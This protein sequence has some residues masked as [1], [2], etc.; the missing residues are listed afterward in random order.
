MSTLSTIV[1]TLQFPRKVLYLILRQTEGTKLFWRSIQ[2]PFQRTEPDVWKAQ[3]AGQ[4]LIVRELQLAANI[5]SQK[6]PLLIGLHGYGSDE[7]QMKTL[8]GVELDQPFIYLAPRAP[9]PHPTGGYAWFPINVNTGAVNNGAFEFEA[10]QIKSSLDLIAALIPQAV[11]RY[12]A[13][14]ERVFV[15]GYSQGAAMSLAFML[16]H[17]QRIAG[18]A[19]MSGQLLDAI[20]PYVVPPLDQQKPFFLG[21]GTKDQFITPEGMTAAK[22]YLTSRNVAVTYRTYPIPHVV[23]QAELRDL[24]AWIEPFLETV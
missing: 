20:K 6:P 7:R 17:P 21:Y 13:D 2:R 8:V 11:E 24:E 18:A 22:A 23:S 5:S 16:T 19:A 15:I 14:P 1:Q 12:G 10:T 4:P 3:I 9:Y